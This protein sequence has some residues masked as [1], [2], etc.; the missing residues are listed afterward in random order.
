MLHPLIRILRERY[1]SFFDLQY[2]ARVSPSTLRGVV[3]FAHRPRLGVQERIA[4]ALGVE[5]EEIWPAEE[6]GER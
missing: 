4:R 6:G 1:L 3:R 5:V 2:L